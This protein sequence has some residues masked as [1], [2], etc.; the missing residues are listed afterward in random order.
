MPMCCTQE[1]AAPKPLGQDSQRVVV[2]FPVSPRGHLPHQATFLVSL[3]WGWMLLAFSDRD[4]SQ[5]STIHRTPPQQ[6]ITRPH[7]PT[8]PRRKGPALG[9][10]ILPMARVEKGETTTDTVDVH[11]PLSP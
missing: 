7:K 4:V 1:T 11:C 5:C 10:A 8:E 3:K 2:F 9:E 6:R